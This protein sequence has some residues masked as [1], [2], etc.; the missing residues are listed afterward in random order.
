MTENRA[1][2][3]GVP[4]QIAM[5]S[6]SLC[7]P[8]SMKSAEHFAE[9]AKVAFRGNTRNWETSIPDIPVVRSLEGGQMPYFIVMEY[10]R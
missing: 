7:H 2:K 8:Y 3:T 5:I 9:L 10:E 6:A 4:E 1:G